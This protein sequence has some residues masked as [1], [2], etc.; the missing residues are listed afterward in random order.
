MDDDHKREFID[1]EK[2]TDGEWREFNFNNQQLGVVDKKASSVLTINSL[3]IGLSPISFVLGDIKDQS[4]LLASIFGVILL[5]ASV[6][7]CLF[8]VMIKWSTQLETREKIIVLRNKKERYLEMSVYL[9]FVA[10]ILFGFVF[11]F[12]VYLKS[13]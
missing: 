3:L 2:M 7:F 8:T 6:F 11:S 5:L 9:L 4:I 10:L 13:Q 1:V 12:G